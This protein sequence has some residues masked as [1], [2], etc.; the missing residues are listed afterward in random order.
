MA[1][2]Q[3]DVKTRQSDEQHYAYN[4]FKKFFGRDPSDVEL[5]QATSAYS[6]GDPNR[7]NVQG[8]DSFVAQMYQQMNPNADNQKNAPGK[9]G[10]V[11]SLFN[12]YVGRAATQEEKDHFGSILA[13]GQYTAYQIGDALKQ[14]P[15]SV[16]AQ[17]QEFRKSIG[18]ELQQGDERYFKESVLPS[19]QSSFAQQGRSVD[20]SGYAAA[21]AQAATQQNRQRESFMSNLSA[22]QYQGNKQNAYAAYVGDRDYTRGRSDTIADRNTSRLYDIQDYS[23]QKQAYDEYLRKYGKRSSLSSGIAGAF[24]GGMTGGMVGGPWGAIAGAAGGGLLGSFGG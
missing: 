5:A 9:Y 13:S 17:D 20:S 3:G 16:R 21:L 19:I 18:T 14:L 4:A 2:Y 8:G 23:M 11:D 7:P 22:Q 10:E 6:S 1:T 24:S 15:E 12:Q